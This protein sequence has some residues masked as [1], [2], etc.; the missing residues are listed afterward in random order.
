MI[1]GIIVGMTLRHYRETGD[2]LISKWVHGSDANAQ[3][4]SQKPAEENPED[5]KE[6]EPSTP[7]E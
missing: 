7:P 1:A 6:Q 3:D 2:F 4:D 5:G